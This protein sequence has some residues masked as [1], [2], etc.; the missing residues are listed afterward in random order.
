VLVAGGRD[1]NRHPVATAEL[2]DPVAGTFATTGS[3]GT[4]RTQQT[5]TLLNDGTVLV[6]GGIG[7]TENDLVSAEIFDPNAGSFAPTDTMQTSRVFN[8][9]TLLNNGKVLV[10]G[11]TSAARLRRQRYTNSWE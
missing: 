11:G 7:A 1:Q 10:T 9:P 8:T 2:F 5:A 6:A 4:P 3:M